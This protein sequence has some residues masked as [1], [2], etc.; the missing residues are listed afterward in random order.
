MQSG[1]EGRRADTQAA[2]IYLL[3]VI[4]FISLAG[5]GVFIGGGWLYAQGQA[6]ERGWKLDCIARGG[7]LVE[8]IG[9][10]TSFDCV[11]PHTP[12]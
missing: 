2:A 6:R 10:F 4:S 7:S 12:R 5:Y 11:G 8:H 9:G 1:S 3:F